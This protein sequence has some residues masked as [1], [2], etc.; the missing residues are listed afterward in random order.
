MVIGEKKWRFIPNQNSTIYGINDAGIETFTAHIVHSLVRETIQN[1]LDAINDLEKP[2]TVEFHQFNMDIRRFP[3]HEGFRNY[4]KKCLES[5][6]D[7]ADAERFFKRAIKLFADEL[8][9]MRVSD[10][11]TCGLLGAESGEKGSSWS[12]LVKESGSSNKHQ[13]SGGSFGIGKSAAFACSDFRT[14]FYSS[15]DN[16]G[17][18]SNIGVARLVSF[19]EEKF[20]KENDA[21]WTTGI[22]YFS[23]SEKLT[24][25]QKLPCFED[26][27][28]RNTSGTDLYIMG[29]PD[30]ENLEQEMLKSV[31]INFLVSIW[32][33]KLIV[34][35][36]HMDI[37]KENL[38]QYIDCLNPYDGEEIKQLIDYYRV[39]TSPSSVVKRIKLDSKE[40]GERYGFKDGE[41]TLLLMEGNNL[42]S[43]VMMTRSAGMKLFN[44]DHISGTIDFTG[45]L[46][47][48][49][50]EMNKQFRKM[51][52]P[53]H[54]AWEPGR[55]KDEAA[56]AKK[57]YA[58]LRKY[59]RDKVKDLFAKAG[60]EPMDAFGASDFLPDNMPGDSA[61]TEKEEQFR[62]TIQRLESKEMSV[63]SKKSRKIEI[64]VD[65]NEK[66]DDIYYENGNGKYRG[67]RKWGQSGS[68]PG[69]EKGY[70]LVE[71]KKRI[72]CKDKKR[73]I[74]TIKYVVPGNAKMARLDFVING[75]QSNYGFPVKKAVV[76][77]GKVHI[78]QIKDNKVY[79]SDVRKSDIVLLELEMDFNQYCLMEVNY[80]E[81]KK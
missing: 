20:K 26:E 80:Y 41:C 16:M 8:R 6:K 4:L 75:E 31:L 71:V 36:N 48:E 1:S 34:K 70:R 61:K 21:G 50:E 3:D 40:Y 10:Y 15:L 27:Y 77:S 51:E 44:Q 74:Y 58:D 69:N 68:E 38:E 2:V 57:M 32:K 33:G 39:L 76:S 22:G 19:I 60:D 9:V 72:I 29:F 35:I 81:S 46:M 37:S 54:D 28:K 79:L 47:I 66:G 17:V 53:S 24:A 55:C 52:V 56:R 14:V 11:N 25:I 13:T 7:E 30:M 73:G 78:E 12:R 5:N 64:E 63:I 43:R 45:I 62:Y 67:K 23:D 49:G 59:I 65:S 42:N 18:E